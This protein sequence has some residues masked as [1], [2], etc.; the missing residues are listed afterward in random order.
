MLAAVAVAAQAATIV[1]GRARCDVPDV[2][3]TQSALTDTALYAGQVVNGGS[4]LQAVQLLRFDALSGDLRVLRTIVSSNTGEATFAVAERNADVIYAVDNRPPAATLYS[5]IRTADRGATWTTVRTL[6]CLPR[7]RAG[8]F[9]QSAIV[10]CDGQ[11][12]VSADGGATWRSL[13]QGSYAFSRTS[14][15]TLFRY[16]SLAGGA[17]HRS[18]DGGL[19]FAPAAMRGFVPQ[20]GSR[21]EPDANDSRTLYFLTWGNA[22]FHYQFSRNGGDD[23]TGVG[24]WP[25][26]QRFAVA[27]TTGTLYTR[28][29]TGPLLR[30]RD[31]GATW[32]PLSALPAVT[33]TCQ[34]FP[35]PAVG[36]TTAGGTIVFPELALLALLDASTNVEAAAIPLAPAWPIIAAILLAATAAIALRRRQRSR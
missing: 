5:V 9:G 30:S 1:G 20:V 2:A 18:D 16:A 21:F 23:W 7:L 34:R 14:D 24:T 27:G 4:S 17:V 10:E 15:A 3:H 25:G 13:P 11:A 28:P 35:S 31:F 32:E 29:L 19:T 6:A 22:G 12:E 36:A 8:P 26:N 33:T